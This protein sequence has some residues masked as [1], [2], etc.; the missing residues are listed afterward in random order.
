MNPLERAA[1][2]SR[3]AQVNVAEKGLPL[4]GLV[5]LAIA[6]D[7]KVLPLFAVIVA[8]MAVAARVPWRIYLGIL[9]GALLFIAIGAIPLVVNVTM[10][11]FVS[12]P[13]GWAHAGTVLGRSAVGMAATLL[14]AL[15][16][17]M[18][19][20][21]MWAKSVGMPSSLVTLVMLMY[22]MSSTLIATAQEMWEAQA[23]RL[24]HSSLRRWIASSGAQAASLFVLSFSRA[25]ALQEG[26]ELRAPTLQVVYDRRPLRRY[27]L[28]VEVLLL[29]LV[30]MIGMVL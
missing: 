29:L 15:T 7:P 11:G 23:A 5:F 10:Q 8:A 30:L 27:V 26:L 25:R 9:F 6:L 21:L 14:F 13:H 2:R 16:T 19:E 12:V 4:L 24:G 3:W 18:A 20:L 17:P 28:A 1:A 22:R